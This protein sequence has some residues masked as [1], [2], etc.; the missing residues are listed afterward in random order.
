MDKRRI[1]LTIEW[2]KFKDNF[3]QLLDSHPA[4]KEKMNKGIVYY[5][6]DKDEPKKLQVILAF[7]EQPLNVFRTS[8]GGLKVDTQWG[9]RLFYT[10][11]YNGSVI[12]SI[13][14]YDDSVHTVKTYTSA[15]KITEKEFKR[16]VSKFFLVEQCT[17]QEIQLNALQKIRFFVMKN[18]TVN[19]LV[20][21]VVRVI[22]VI[23]R[24]FT[25]GNAR[26][27]SQ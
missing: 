16:H 14:G 17:N 12:C 6:S 26:N 13:R 21:L 20:K 3:N 10:L 24:I 7:Y 11:Q 8:N 23:K 5:S 22:P 9:C 27:D 19:N 4:L 15:A 2:N 25:G 18:L 1:E